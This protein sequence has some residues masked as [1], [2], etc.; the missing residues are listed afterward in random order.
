MEIDK[1]AIFHSP[2]ACRSPF[3][4][5]DVQA[6]TPTPSYAVTCYICYTVDISPWVG[7]ETSSLIDYRS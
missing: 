4:G 7:N 6:I 1:I 5:L 2:F 3:A